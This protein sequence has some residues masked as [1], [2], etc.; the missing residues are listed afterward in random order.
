MSRAR[1]EKDG[2]DRG[3]GLHQRMCGTFQVMVRTEDIFSKE[4]GNLWRILR[5]EA[6]DV[7]VCEDV[8]AHVCN[9]VSSS[10]RNRW[11]MMETGKDKIS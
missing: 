6:T 3:Q 5:Q 10:C 1:P 7:H 9:G 8:C 4:T 11:E 2:A